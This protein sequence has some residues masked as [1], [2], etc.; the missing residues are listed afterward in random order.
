M[1]LSCSWGRFG[2]PHNRGSGS[3]LLY[4]DEHQDETNVLRGRGEDKIQSRFI[5]HERRHF[6]QKETQQVP[7]NSK[8]KQR[9]RKVRTDRSQLRSSQ[10]CDQ[11]EFSV[12]HFLLCRMG[13]T[14]VPTLQR[15]V[16]RK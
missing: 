7:F 16:R 4:E 10:G 8:G 14:K 1:E 9:G 5:P 6:H 15:C 2:S 3:F 11:D 12:P 13:T